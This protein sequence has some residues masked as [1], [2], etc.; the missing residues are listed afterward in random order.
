MRLREEE[1]MMGGGWGYGP[2]MDSLVAI[3]W[4]G[5]AKKD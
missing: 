4:H 1:P 5:G 3:W 2:V